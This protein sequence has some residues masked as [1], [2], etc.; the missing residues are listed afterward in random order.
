MTLPKVEPDLTFTITKIISN[1]ST[2]KLQAEVLSREPYMAGKSKAMVSRVANRCKCAIEEITDLLGAKR[3]DIIKKELIHPDN[4]LQ[5]DN[6]TNMVIAMPDGIRNEIEDYITS[7][8]NVY[9]LNL[10]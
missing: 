5:I 8:Y 10:K 9:S 1:L 7:R 2:A 6:I 4:Y 3:A